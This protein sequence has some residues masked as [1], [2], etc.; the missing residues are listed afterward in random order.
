MG[1]AV[2]TSSSVT[3]RTRRVCEVGA[4]VSRKKKPA[5][6][7]FRVELFFWPENGK[8]KPLF[9]YTRQTRCYPRGREGGSGVCVAGSGGMKGWSESWKCQP[10]RV[11]CTVRVN[12][13][14]VFRMDDSDSSFDTKTSACACIAFPDGIITWSADY[15][16]QSTGGDTKET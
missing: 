6:P 5:P 14:N 8:T 11:A 4:I 3:L 10:F 2:L 13:D 1:F 12:C 7:I 16:H 15:T 9:I